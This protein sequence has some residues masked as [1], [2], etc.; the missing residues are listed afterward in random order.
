[1]IVI[2][3]V[4]TCFRCGAEYPNNVIVCR[5]CDDSKR[6]SETMRNSLG[7]DA[8]P[9]DRHLNEGISHYR[10]RKEKFYN[11]KEKLEKFIHKFFLFGLSLGSFKDSDK[12][13]LSEK[14]TLYHGFDA[15]GYHYTIRRDKI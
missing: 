13:A 14:D 1:M 7:M 11:I 5:I 9:R 6:H 3:G 12:K 8:S 15:E 4:W 2:K 10:K